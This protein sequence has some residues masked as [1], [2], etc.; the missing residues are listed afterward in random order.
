[1]KKRVVLPQNAELSVKKRSRKNLTS[2]RRI[3]K[4]MCAFLKRKP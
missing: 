3:N 4:N 2:N 1:M